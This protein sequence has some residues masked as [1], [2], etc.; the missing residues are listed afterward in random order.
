M[1][2][3]EKERIRKLIQAEND[4]LITTHVDPDGDAIGSTFATY[5]FLEG[6]GKKATVYLRDN[7]PYR[8]SFLPKPVRI[9]RTLENLEYNS[10]FVLDCGDL[11]RI[12][13]EVELLKKDIEIVN[14][15]H[16]ETN[17]MFGSINYVVKEACATSAILYEILRELNFPINYNIAINIYTGVFTDTGSFRYPNTNKDAFRICGQMIDFGVEPSY[18]ARMVYEAH[19]PERFFLLS[20]VLK[21]IDVIDKI[22]IAYLTR[23]MLKETN[24]NYEHSDGFVEYLNEIKGVEVACLIRELAERKWKISMRSKGERDVSKICRVFGGGGHRSA[25]G[26]VLDGDLTEVKEML[27]ETLRKEK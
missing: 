22:V 2:E 15:D 6:L 25:A 27:L 26:C 9:E 21:T 24:A 13:D 1:I 18:V 17:S 3:K 8:Y 5:F 19:P 10:V 20:R 14:I 12:G 23:E 4:F 16:H 11:S 7:V